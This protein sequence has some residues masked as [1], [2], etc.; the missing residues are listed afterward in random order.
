MITFQIAGYLT[1]FAG[2]RAELEL[3][4]SPET[5]G[6][7]LE[8]LCR[9]HV[10][11]RDRVLNEQGE[12]RRHVNVFV[13]NQHFPGQDVLDV[14]ISDGA[15]ICIMLAI[16]GGADHGLRGLRVSVVNHPRWL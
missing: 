10:G 12:V 7:A 14:A 4:A 3:D 9:R 6:Q 11:L 16:S 8:E 2:G 15:E 1:E 13:N 5:V